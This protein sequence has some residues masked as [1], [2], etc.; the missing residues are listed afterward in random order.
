MKTV[1]TNL[2]T[3]VAFLFFYSTQNDVNN[4][5]RRPWFFLIRHFKIFK[6]ELKKRPINGSAVNYQQ[7]A[8]KLSQNLA[9]P[10]VKRRRNGPIRD[11]QATTRKWTGHLLSS[12]HFCTLSPSPSRPRALKSDCRRARVQGVRVCRPAEI[13]CCGRWRR[14]SSGSGRWPWPGCSGG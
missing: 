8:A 4:N 9:F 11:D 5:V 3:V 6:L 10:N 1:W 12:T 2:H 14:R 13:S 7:M